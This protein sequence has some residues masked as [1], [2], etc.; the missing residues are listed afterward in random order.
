[1][2]D[3]KFKS[4]FS[5]LFL[6]LLF[7]FNN[8]IIYSNQTC[9]YSTVFQKQLQMLSFN[10]VKISRRINHQIRLTL[11]Q[12]L[13]EMKK[14]NHGS[15]QVSEK[16]KRSFHQTQINIT[17]NTHPN[18]VLKNILRFVKNYYSVKTTQLLRKVVLPHANHYQVP[19]HS[20]LV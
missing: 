2:I 6:I 10:Q 20:T 16:L 15:Y 5:L 13:T 19:V 14:V 12:V 17:R 1:M 3:V 4:S 7:Y 9:Q 8:L 11:V 18:Q